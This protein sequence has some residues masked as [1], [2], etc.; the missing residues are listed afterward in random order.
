MNGVSVGWAWM[1]VALLLSNADYSSEG[2]INQNPNDQM[3]R[4]SGD[5]VHTTFI[6]RLDVKP[7][8][9]GSEH[10][11]TMLFRNIYINQ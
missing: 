11:T 2:V 8:T 5:F 4:E 1:N 9:T 6:R 3:V 7:E 10:F